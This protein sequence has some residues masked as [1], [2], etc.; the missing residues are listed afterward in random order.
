MMFPDRAVVERLREQFP[1]GCRIVLDAMDDPYVTIPPGT[2]GVCHG[3][4]DVGSVMC[5]WDDGN[6]SL[7]VAYGADHAHRVESEDEIKVSLDWLGKR[8]REAATGPFHCPRCGASLDSLARHALSRR[9]DV[10]RVPPRPDLGQGFCSFV[11]L[12][13]PATP[14]QRLDF[15][16][17]RLFRA[18]LTPTTARRREPYDATGNQDARRP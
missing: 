12:S 4:D 18:I 6:G 5:S 9:A 10:I 15:S 3:V 11:C 1:V 14:K 7:S 16:C 8:Q 13:S 2:Q 17:C